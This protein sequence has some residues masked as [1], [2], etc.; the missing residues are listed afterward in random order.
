MFDDR[1]SSGFSERAE[2]HI[3]AENEIGPLLVELS[4]LTAQSHDFTMRMEELIR[5]MC[6]HRSLCAFLMHLFNQKYLYFI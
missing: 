2:L 5:E 1:R 4:R 3:D 6:F